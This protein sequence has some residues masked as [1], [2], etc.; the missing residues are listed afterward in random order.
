MKGVNNNSIISSIDE[1]NCSRKELI[2]DNILSRLEKVNGHTVGIYSLEAKKDSD[3]IRHSAIIDVINGLKNKGINILYYSSD[4]SLQ[5]FKE[6]SDI[7]LV[8]RYVSSFD[9]V[10]EKVYTRDVFKR[11]WYII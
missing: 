6:K 10:K 11:D 2:V 7:I 5:S 1:S 8:N 9:D 3:N 4:I